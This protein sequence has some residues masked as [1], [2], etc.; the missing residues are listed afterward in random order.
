MKTL[1]GWRSCHHDFL[2]TR[3]EEEAGNPHHS[4]I[5]SVAWRLHTA[6]SGVCMGDGSADT[7]DNPAHTLDNP[8]DT[9]DKGRGLIG[10]WPLSPDDRA[11]WLDSE[12][13]MAD[14][15]PGLLDRSGG[16]RSKRANTLDKGSHASG[17]DMD[18]LDR[19]AHRLDRGAGEVGGLGQAPTPR[20]F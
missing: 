3:N 4:W 11:D 7:L 18:P 19:T 10:K 8:A 15:S 14:G 12:V 5:S 17:R 6:E 20:E 9:L 2:R 16:S 13:S 1:T